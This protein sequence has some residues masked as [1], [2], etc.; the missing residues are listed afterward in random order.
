MSK[1]RPVAG[2][3][4]LDG[5][6]AVLPGWAA[7]WLETRTDLARQRV[8][9]RGQDPG[10]DEVLIRI[11]AVAMAW[12]AAGSAA[13]ATAGTRSPSPPELPRNSA[14]GVTE[15]ADL[16]G[17]GNRAVCKAIAEQRLP[18]TRVGGRWLLDR[19]DVEQFRANRAA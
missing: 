13:G 11:R 12:A 5:A 7:H 16:I 14:C 15:A 8:V 4:G 2:V 3:V 6:E 17:I 9:H 1:T 18:A 10:V 19:V